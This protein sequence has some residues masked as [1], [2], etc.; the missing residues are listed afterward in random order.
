MSRTP[1]APRIRDRRCRASGERGTTLLE[2]LVSTAILVLVIGAAYASLITQ[3]RR[4]A[5]QMM[6][7]EMLHA[8]RL[9]FDTMTAEIANAG[10][11]V[12]NPAV[13]SVA[14]SIVVAGPSKLQFWTVTS[15]AHT[16]LTAVAAKNTSAAAVLST[17][18]L[19][20]GASLYLSDESRWYFGT[21]RSIS[22]NTVQLSPPL[23]YDFA[24]GSL[25]TPAVL[26][27]YELAN[28]ALTRNGHALIP[29]VS[30]LR[31]TYD[32]ATP[33]AVTQIDISMTVQAR[34]TDLG[35]A[36]PTMTLQARLA[37][38]NLVL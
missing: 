31:F 2:V 20:P 13:P 26:V 14:P 34:A 4:Q 15:T 11:G 29:N 38:P 36:R 37:P 1:R 16:F 24:A 3:L 35:G 27:T 6:V 9:A 18:G 21:I 5:A 17:A 28:G 12:P 32:A 23:P 25:L 8:G 33:G 19:T 30:A 10:F 7:A 22:G